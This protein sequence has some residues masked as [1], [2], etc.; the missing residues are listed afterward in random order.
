MFAQPGDALYTSEFSV[1]YDPETGQERIKRNITTT[2]ITYEDCLKRVKTH[3]VQ[4]LLS[5]Y[6]MC[7]ELL[8]YETDYLT[9]TDNGGPLAYKNNGTWYL[10]G[11]LS[12]YGDKLLT[13]GTPFIASNISFSL[14]WIQ[15]NM[16][17]W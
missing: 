4:Q 2:L 14:D 16:R 1:I 15:D 9:F 11:L 3:E 17:P 13:K 8:F 10:A 6:S 12:I 5:P 7:V